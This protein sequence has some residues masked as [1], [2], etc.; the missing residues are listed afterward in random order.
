MQRAIETFLPS[1]QHAR[2]LTLDFIRA[3]P[4]SRLHWSPHRRYGTLAKQFRHLICVQGVY[5][6]GLRGGTASFAAKHSHYAGPLER[7]ALLDGLIAKDELLEQTL[8]AIPA[9]SEEDFEIEFYGRQKLRTYLNT[10]LYHEALHQ[11]QWSFYASLG[12]FETPRSW[13]LNWGL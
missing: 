7:Q 1:W 11:G 13:Q 12:G 3:V 8:R 10:F 2:G 5:L 4:D 9:A 6:D